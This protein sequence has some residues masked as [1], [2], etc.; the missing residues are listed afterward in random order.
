MT[1]IRCVHF[2]IDRSAKSSDRGIKMAVSADKRGFW[3]QHSGD[4][5][6]EMV[7]QTRKGR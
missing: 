4:E 3:H 6:S 5:S 2:V 7:K 1:R